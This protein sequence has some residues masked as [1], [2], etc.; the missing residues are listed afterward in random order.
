MLRPRLLLTATALLLGSLAAA[1]ANALS[2]QP[3]GAA[4]AGC[5]IPAEQ[6]GGT[7]A[8]YEIESGGLA[9][10]Y[11]LR[12]PDGYER[13]D[14]WPLVIA[15]HGRG[16]TGTEVEG[17]SKLSRLPAV[18]AY[19]NGAIG[20]GDGYRQAWQGAP[21]EPP[22]VD[23][24]AFTE[25]L[26]DELQSTLCVDPGRTYATGKSNGAGLVGQLACR[27]PDRFAA[28]APVA[29]AFYPGSLAGCAQARPVPVLELHG[30]GDTTI[31]Y[32]GDP[33]RDLPAV[34]DWVG[35]WVERDG[36]RP[37]PSVSTIGSDVTRYHWSGC[38]DDTA[39]QHVAVTGGGHVWPGADVYSGGGYVT[40]TIEAH[41][42]IWRFFRRHRLADASSME[43]LR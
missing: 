32:D 31:P 21:Y 9:R 37:D 7:S 43:A 28:V 26:L 35:A 38:A 12:L 36:C 39:V 5:Q 3:A 42:V 24:V 33:A 13:R 27:L 29:G 4:D 41:R 1:P 6:P 22:G 18:V 20:T 8:L 34:R 40:S 16:S 17:Y 11:I 10:S 25:D 15:Y 14:S 30:T 2:P 23:D 19:P